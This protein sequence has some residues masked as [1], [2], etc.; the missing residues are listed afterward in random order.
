M[1]RAVALLLAVILLVGCG[2]SSSPAAVTPPMPGHRQANRPGAREPA[3]AAIRRAVLQMSL[4]EAQSAL[5]AA[6][7]R[8]RRQGSEGSPSASRATPPRS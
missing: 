6:I 2:S 4:E 1:L 7:S 3:C 8:A 5:D